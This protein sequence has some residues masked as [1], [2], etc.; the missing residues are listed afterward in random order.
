MFASVD[1]ETRMRMN[2][3]HNKLV[4]PIKK[5]VETALKLSASAPIDSL[6]RQRVH[7]IDIDNGVTFHIS[8]LHPKNQHK[9]L[10]LEDLESG[11]FIKTDEIAP[12]GTILYTTHSLQ[13]PS[14]PNAVNQESISLLRGLL[15][16]GIIKAEESLRRAKPIMIVDAQ[17]ID[18]PAFPRSLVPRN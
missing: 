14:H 9:N 2:S 7:V 6:G 8:N 5:L 18:L 1:S 15:P 12:D 16:E 11:L 3:A 13:T 10:K 4:G 17:A